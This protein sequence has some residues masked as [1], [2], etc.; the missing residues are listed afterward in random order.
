MMTCIGVGGAGAGSAGV[1]VAGS[2]VGIGS[3]RGRIVPPPAPGDASGVSVDGDEGRVPLLHPHA[4][5]AHVSARTR[6]NFFNG[7][8]ASVANEVPAEIVEKT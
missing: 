6:D 5:K 8:A 3:S 7:M 2:G 4:A 1:G